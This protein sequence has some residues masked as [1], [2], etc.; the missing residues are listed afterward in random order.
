MVV[1]CCGVKCASPGRKKVA[2]FRGVKTSQACAWAHYKASVDERGNFFL[3][4]FLAAN[5]KM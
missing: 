5:A 1:L 2:L 3:S 4:F